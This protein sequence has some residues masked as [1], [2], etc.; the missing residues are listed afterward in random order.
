MRI[1]SWR[2]CPIR[3]R[4]IWQ[5]SLFGVLCFFCWSCSTS[6]RVQQRVRGI[7]ILYETSTPVIDA[8]LNDLNHLPDSLVA[9]IQKIEFVKEIEPGIYGRAWA[10][11][12]IQLDLNDYSS[13]RLL[14]ESFHLQDFCAC[15]TA[16]CSDDDTFLDEWATYQDRLT[17]IQQTDRLEGYAGVKT[18]QYLHEYEKRKWER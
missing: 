17:P 14:H 5:K 12:T 15:K 13:T 18:W 16:Y 10:N 3:R 9:Y 4:K 11:G 2:S 6:L 8:Y 1:Q 7:P